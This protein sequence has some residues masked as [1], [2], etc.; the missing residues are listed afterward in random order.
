MTDFNFYFGA[1]SGS[2][3]KALRQLEEPNVMIN[4]ATDKNK[5]FSTIEKLFIDSGGYSF[6]LGKGKYQTTDREYLKYIEKHQPKLFAFRDYPCEPEVLSEYDRTVEQHQKYTTWRHRRLKALMSEFNINSQPVSVVQ[7][8]ELDDYVRHVETLKEENLLTDYVAIGS[9][10]RRN[11]DTRIRKIINEVS[12]RIGDRKLHAFGVKSNVLRFSEVRN[13][14]D[15]A[16]SLAYSYG[17]RYSDSVD[18]D[19]SNNFRDEALEY[20]KF[21]KQINQN[22]KSNE[23]CKQQT[24]EVEA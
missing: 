2:E 18:G 10:C 19:G 5:P 11:Q 21:K 4:Y 12:S 20:L 1:A 17:S 3:R 9:I 15:S 7:G 6:I 8:W 13:K 22:L 14:L 16:D 23:S 24:L